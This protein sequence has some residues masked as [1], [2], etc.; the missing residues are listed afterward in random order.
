MDESGRK[1]PC[2]IPGFDA[3]GE[4][5]EPLYYVTIPDRWLV[6]HAI[7]RDRAI[8]SADGELGSS[9]GLTFAVSMALAE[10]WHLPGLGGN[11]DNW[12]L[13]EMDLEMVRWVNSVVWADFQACFYVKKK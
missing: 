7:R 5:G 10:D 12:N 8:E 9:D 13:E 6:R 2:P 3:T 1:I 11:P 4:D